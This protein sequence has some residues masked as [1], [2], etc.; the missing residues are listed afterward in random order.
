MLLDLGSFFLSCHPGVYPTKTQ[1]GGQTSWI[2]EKSEYLSLSPRAH[3]VEG[4]KRLPEV[5]L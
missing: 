3:V 1:Q 2:S 4:K 5:I